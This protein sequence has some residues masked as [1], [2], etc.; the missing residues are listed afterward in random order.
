MVV[1]CNQ[2][3]DMQLYA[4]QAHKNAERS[5]MILAW[6]CFDGTSTQVVDLDLFLRFPKK[7]IEV[8]FMLVSCDIYDMVMSCISLNWKD[9]H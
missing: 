6:C 7:F 4:I 1:I 2:V 5:A 3:N 8:S 9:I